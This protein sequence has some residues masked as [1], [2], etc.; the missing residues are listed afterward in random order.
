MF[1]KRKQKYGSVRIKHH[2]GYSFASKLEGDLFD[3]LEILKKGGNIKDIVVQNSVYLTAARIQYIADF[4][5]FDIELNE[6]SWW[7]AKG[8]ET[9][10]WRIKRRLWKHYGPG[11]LHVYK[12]QGRG[13]YLA[14]T[15]VPKINGYN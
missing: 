12:R 7:E 10:V 5:A 14:E 11:L 2:A 4:K 3:F 1:P 9:D 6:Y 8:F 13:L 15:I